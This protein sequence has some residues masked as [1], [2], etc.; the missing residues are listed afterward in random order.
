MQR[1]LPFDYQGL[2]HLP[3]IAKWKRDLEIYS[4]LHHQS[5]PL[6]LLTKQGLWAIAQYRLS[7]WIDQ[8]VRLPMIRPLLQGICLIWKKLIELTMG[9]ELPRQVTIDQGLFL[10]HAQNIVLHP[11]VRMGRDC[12][13]SHG[14]TIGLAGRGANQGTPE[15]G[16]RVYIAPGAKVFGKIRIGDD[17][18][19]GANAVVTKDLPDGA[20]AVG[21]P[22]KVISYQG[23]GDFL[24]YLDSE[25]QKQMVSEPAK[26][27]VEFTSSDLTEPIALRS[28]RHEKN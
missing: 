11:D 13:I 24:H 15:I 28:I 18:A 21:I 6:L 8:Q 1:Y 25:G 5:W 14:V 22:A 7:A 20:V 17:V 2:Q 26:I 19:I 3:M 9:I 27:S 23:S 4:R 12:T 10:P 16:N